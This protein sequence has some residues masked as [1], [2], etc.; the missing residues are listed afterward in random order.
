MKAHEL[1][2]RI[3]PESVPLR[4]D[5]APAPSTDESTD[6]ST[7][8]DELEKARSPRTDADAPVKLSAHAEHRIE[9]RNISLD[10]AERRSLADAMHA[11]DD[12]GSR[13]ALL[14]RSDAA[15]VVNVS[16]RTV[17]TAMN[18]AELEQRIFTDIDSAML[19]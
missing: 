9:Q 13:E 15:F 12:K 6:A 19:V 10:A 5:D 17:I 16:D 4:R 8:A 11:L 1:A 14:L 2:A 7:F 3:N 18:Q